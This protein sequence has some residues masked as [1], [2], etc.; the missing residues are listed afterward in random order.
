[1]AVN[2]KPDYIDTIVYSQERFEKDQQLV[3]DYCRKT[4]CKECLLLKHGLDACKDMYSDYHPLDDASYTK[5]CADALRE[6][7]HA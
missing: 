6:D 5:Q 3:R 7:D 2:K 4:N 1:M